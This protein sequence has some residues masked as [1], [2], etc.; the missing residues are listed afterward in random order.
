M[1]N[2]RSTDVEGFVNF[3]VNST[4]Y[5]NS[6]E[7][8]MVVKLVVVE[9]PEESLSICCGGNVYDVLSEVL[10]ADDQRPYPRS[11]ETPYTLESI[12][13]EQEA[14]RLWEEFHFPNIK[15]HSIQDVSKE[16]SVPYRAVIVMGTTGWSSSFED[17]GMW[18]ATYDDLTSDGK[19]LYGLVRKLN[20]GCTLH[21]LTFLDT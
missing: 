2:R 8:G 21:L 5:H 12:Q 10:V 18:Y 9:P 20:P 15:N 16:M 14:I 4:K 17:D 11:N 13:R 6:R 3:P 1:M 7:G 19:E